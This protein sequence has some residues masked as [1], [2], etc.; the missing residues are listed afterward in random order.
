MGCRVEQ[1]IPRSVCDITL[2]LHIRT[3]QSLELVHCPIGR[4]CICVPAIWDP[5]TADPYVKIDPTGA[6][7][8]TTSQYH[9]AKLP[10]TA[11]MNSPT[12][13]SKS[14]VVTKFQWSSLMLWAMERNVPILSM[15]CN[16]VQKL[17]TG[18]CHFIPGLVT[19]HVH[20][21]DY[22]SRKSAVNCPLSIYPLYYGTCSLRCKHKASNQYCHRTDF[23][24]IEARFYWDSAVSY[25]CVVYT[26]SVHSFFW[27]QKCIDCDATQETPVCWR[28]QV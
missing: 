28:V 13:I 9:P 16:Y 21:M 10:L 27:W 19:L 7:L 18:T 15:P 26:T 12:S 23:G 4:T 11:F 14:P 3:V 25:W 22:E 6:H 2:I 17:S 20:R 1:S 8:S 5:Y 24:P